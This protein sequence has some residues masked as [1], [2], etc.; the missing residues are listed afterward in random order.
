M[1]QSPTGVIVY[2]YQVGFGDCFL[3]RF[4]YPGRD[5]HVLIDF[6][7]TGLPKE[8]DKKQMQNIANDI[9]QRCGGK[10]EAVVATHRHADHISGFATNAQGTAPGDVIRG[11]KP[12]VVIQPWTEQPDLA[13]NAVGPAGS[14]ALKSM[15]QHTQSLRS[16]HQVAQ[17]I[18]TLA[19]SG[20]GKALPQGIREQL[21]FIGEDNL[22]NLSAVKNLMNIG[23]KQ[24]YVY[25]GSNAGLATVLPGVK[26]HVLGPPTLRQTET[27][28]KQR[29]RDP[30]EFWQ[31]HL[32]LLDAAGGTTNTTNV[33]NLFPKFLSQS[34]SKLS[35][36]ARW[37]AK[38]MKDMRGEQL[39]QL[40]RT[41]DTAMNNTSVILLFEVGNKK[42][43]FPGDAQIEN[44]AYALNQPNTKKLLTDVDFYKVGHHGSRNATPRSMWDLFGKRGRK[45]TKGRM[46]SVL[47]TMPGK[48]GAVSSK[49]E[50]PRTTLLR[51]LSRETELLNTHELAIDQLYAE[52]EII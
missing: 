7:S 22:K 20:M 16:M 48:H 9:A 34:G 40:V 27:I 15:H 52:V 41:L 4:R 18:L 30:D 33:A 2:S 31:L 37:L 32:R 38:R 50:V 5:R 51:A 11:L 21:R 39:L 14:V 36:S 29:A 47:S 49:T 46:K 19:D 1:A 25:N 42:L 12:S 13:K 26:V 10:L 35:F 24:R 23:K 28:K 43:L 44:W 8:V 3:L 17:Q 6:G 45:G